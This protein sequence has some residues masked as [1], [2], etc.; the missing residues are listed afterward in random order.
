MFLAGEVDVDEGKAKASDVDCVSVGTWLIPL[1][2]NS[3]A[4]D[5]ILE[6]EVV[7]VD[8]V[9][10]LNVSAADISTLV[11]TVYSKV[12]LVAIVVGS[13]E[14]DVDS[15]LSSDV[16]PDTGSDDNG[17]EDSDIVDADTSVNAEVVANGVASDV[18]GIVD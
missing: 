12:V 11:A 1:E 16:E 10:V 9:S 14:A 17:D 5:W 4:E 3:A 2:G 13:R 8:D 7:M 18:D 6:I 15:N